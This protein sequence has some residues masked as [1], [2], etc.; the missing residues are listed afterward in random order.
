MLKE[1][2]EILEIL[3]YNYNKDKKIIKIMFRQSKI[4]GYEIK[5]FENLL[6]EF[7]LH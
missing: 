3:S 5:E 6:K 7:Y 2:E 1:E 4:L